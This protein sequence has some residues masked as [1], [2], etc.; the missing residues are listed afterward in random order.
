[1]DSAE[2]STNG[3]SAQNLHRLASL[4]DDQSYASYARKTATAFEA[5][6]MQHPFLFS[7]LL[8]AVVAG[9]LGT[10][11]VI[12][13]GDEESCGEATRR[14][15]A[16]LRSSG[17]LGTLARFKKGGWLARRNKLVGALAGD[18]DRPRLVVCEAGA[19]KEEPLDGGLDMKDLGRAVEDI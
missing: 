13:V 9:A 14:L 10:R 3:V 8:P 15:R 5:E 1:M 12:V 18:A 6:V 4:L 16:Q 17:P 2:P 19:G 11:S 7:S